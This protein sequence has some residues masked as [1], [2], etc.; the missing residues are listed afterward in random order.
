MA[1]AKEKKEFIEK[2]QGKRVMVVGMARSGIAAGALLLKIGAKPVLYDAKTEFDLGDLAEKCELALGGDADAVAKSCDMLVLSP[3]V[4]TRLDFIQNAVK[5]GKPVISEIELGYMTSEADFVCIGGTNGKT[6]TTSLTG[7]IFKNAGRNT[8][9]LGNIGIPI[10]EH[11]LETKPGDVIVAETAALQLETIDKFHPRSCALLN[12]TEDHMDRFGTMDYYAECKVR[13]FENQTMDD[14]GVLNFDD[15]ATAAQCFK[16]PSNILWF[17]RKSEVDQGAFLRGGRIVYKQGE[18]EQDIC[19]PEDVYIP[20]DHNL[21]NA[22][23]AVCLAASMGVPSDVIAHTLRTFKGVEHRIEFVCERDGIRFVNDS[24]GTNPDAT[25]KA[26]LAMKTPTVLILGGFDKHSEFEPMFKDMTENIAA[27]V[28]LGATQQKLLDAAKNAGYPGDIILA[29]G[30]EDAVK[31]ATDRA[32]AGY[33]VLLSPACASWGMFKNF[34]E[35]GRV[36]KELVSSDAAQ[37]R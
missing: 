18:T 14:F 1:N 21:E 3:G 2:L 22:L 31:K 28:L 34:E 30:F 32:E 27:V 20:G 17:S 16:L 19:A 24:K 26:V 15:P 8:F 9:V 29:D 37:R 23:A 36:F 10:T 25:I 6:T 12:I 13:M 33:T 35:R 11:S 4:P 5:S 7:E